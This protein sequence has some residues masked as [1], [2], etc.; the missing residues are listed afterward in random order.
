MGCG[1]NPEKAIVRHWVPDFSSETM[2]Q[3][4]NRDDASEME[5]NKDGTVN[6]YMNGRIVFS[7]RYTMATDGKSLM[8]HGLSA[9][10][11]PISME[12]VSLSSKRL[13][14][15]GATTTAFGSPERGDIKVFK[16][17]K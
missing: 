1:S 17:K 8:I 5:F 13:E 6:F 16:P 14:L 12:I 2:K 4:T 15:V 9:L 11:K 10:D 7:T 3:T